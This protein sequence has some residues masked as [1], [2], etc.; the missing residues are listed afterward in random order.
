ML[1]KCV[2]SVVMMFGFLNVAMAGQAVLRPSAASRIVNPANGRDVRVLYMFAL[3]DS[4]AESD[5]I[6]A[7]L[8]VPTNGL[9]E[10]PVAVGRVESSWSTVDGWSSMTGKLSG[11]AGFDGNREE[12]IW[13]SNH[14]ESSEEGTWDTG[15]EVIITEMVKEW[16]FAPRNYGLCLRGIADRNDDLSSAFS[17]DIKEPELVVLYTTR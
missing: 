16:V 11:S 9:S 15:V 17:V 13:T 14:L 2:L 7:V 3:P 1:R 4:V 6:Y 10:V 5:I 8:R 12:C